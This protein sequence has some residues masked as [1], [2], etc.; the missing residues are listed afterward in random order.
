LSGLALAFNLVRT[1]ISG[2]ACAMD[3][4]LKSFFRKLE[5]GSQLS[6][7]IAINVT[8]GTISHLRLYHNM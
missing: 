1:G 2:F 5:G 4:T 6:V 8:E 7:D 3:M